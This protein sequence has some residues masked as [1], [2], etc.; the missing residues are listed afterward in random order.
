MPHAAVSQPQ[1]SWKHEVCFAG[2]NGIEGLCN[3]RDGRH[4]AVKPGNQGAAYHDPRSRAASFDLAR[5]R[6]GGRELIYHNNVTV[7]GFTAV[8]APDEPDNQ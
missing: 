4:L 3:P 5:K 2:D 1:D 6:N 8:Q 7:H